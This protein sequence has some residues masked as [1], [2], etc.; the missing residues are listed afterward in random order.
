MQKVNILAKVSLLIAIYFFTYYAYTG[1]LNPLPADSDSWDYHIPI[2]VSILDGSFL[3]HPKE[4]IPHWHR[5]ASQGTDSSTGLQ[6]IPQWYYPGASEAIN[7]LFI[8]L[9][10]PL[11][12]SNIFAT[13]VLF[14]CLWKLART[15]RLSPDYSLLFAVTICTLNLI[16]R[17]LNVVSV[18]VWVGVWFTLAVILLEKPKQSLS[19]FATLGAVLGMLI[20]SKYT[21]GFFLLTLA[22]FYIRKLL[23]VVTPLRIAALLAP[24]SLFGLFW[25]ARNYI[26]TQNPFYPLPVLGFAGKHLFGGYTV[27]NVG[28]RHPV[29]MINAGFGEYKV[30]LFSIVIALVVLLSH[31]LIKKQS[32]VSPTHKLF[33][34]GILNFIFFLSFPTSEQTWIMISSFRYTI[35]AFIPLILGVFLLA[36]KHKKEELLG[37]IVLAN[38]ISTLTMAY[39]PKLVLLSLPLSLFV[40]YLLDRTNQSEN[41]TH[42]IDK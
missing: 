33:L 13:I 29:D 9:R 38:M 26:L 30:W 18:D 8:L 6:F 42:P 22:V 41:K 37:Y 7:A 36:A 39:Y 20:G 4:V 21:A 2:A 10:V 35:P 28:L 40:V 32:H 23:P 1:I 24:F 34:M 14:F 11:T 16:L 31:F 5:P 25:Y 27:W 17:W 19:Y 15:F 3:S 12:L